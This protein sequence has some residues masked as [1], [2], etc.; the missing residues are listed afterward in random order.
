MGGM[1]ERRPVGLNCVG[2]HCLIMSG[3]DWDDTEINKIHDSVA[4]DGRKLMMTH[5]TTKQKRARVT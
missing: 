4:L 5:T 3:N 2:G 1:L